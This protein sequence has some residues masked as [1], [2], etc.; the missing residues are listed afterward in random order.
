MK[1]K[2]KLICDE[3]GKIMVEDYPKFISESDEEYVQ[4]PYC[5]EIYDKKMV[6]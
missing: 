2:Q 5:H 6:R 4:C 3:C 1:V